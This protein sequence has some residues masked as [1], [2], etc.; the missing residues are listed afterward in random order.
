MVSPAIPAILG[1]GLVLSKIASAV[2]R[3]YGW[4]DDINKELDRHIEDM[5]GS[6]N[7][8]ISRTGRVLQMAKL[9]F[10]IGYVT[11]VAIIAAGQ[12]LL[13]NTFAAVSTIATAATLTNPIAMTCAAIGA[14]LYGWG[15]LSDVERNE[16]LEK[17]SN[18]LEIG[19]ELIKSIVRFVIDKSK[20]LLSSKNFEEIKK[21]IASAAGV[22]GKTLG[23][24][25]HKVTDIV[26]DTFDVVKD[27]SGRAM[28][29]AGGVASD[30][31]RTVAE[32]AGKAAEKT[33]DVVEVAYRAV[34]DTADK[35]AGGIRDKLGK[36]DPKTGQKAIDKK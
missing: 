29:K 6:E 28:E 11:P 22:F 10:G 18:G 1:T 27:R 9:G 21:F 16:I 14:I 33:A 8:T 12:L 20:E 35:A 24:V 5:K 3:L 30:A 25:T 23:D 2:N 13:G 36:S 17:L 32:S 15:A 26:G 19:I 4:A 31:Y 34:A 7:P